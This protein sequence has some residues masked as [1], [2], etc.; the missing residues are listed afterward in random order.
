MYFCSIGRDE[1]YA[2]TDSDKFWRASF[3]LLPSNNVATKR[4]LDGAEFCDIYE[5]R[6][7]SEQ[8]QLI[9]GFLHYMEIINKLKKNINRSENSCKCAGATRKGQ[10]PQIH[11]AN[12]GASAENKSENRRSR[13]E[14]DDSFAGSTGDVRRQEAEDDM[15]QNGVLSCKSPLQD[16]AKAMLEET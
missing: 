1:D 6:T 7:I 10:P 11:Q 5:E 8:H 15:N 9:K 3:V 14:D 16:I 2:L 4:I 12:S 13:A